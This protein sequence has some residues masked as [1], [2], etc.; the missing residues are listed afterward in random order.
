MIKAEEF[1]PFKTDSYHYSYAFTL[2]NKERTHL[3]ISYYLCN[4]SFTL[5]KYTFLALY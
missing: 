5:E 2:Y 3:T 4:L 1:K